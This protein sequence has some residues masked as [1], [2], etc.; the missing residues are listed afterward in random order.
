MTV[1]DRNTGIIQD[2]YIDWTGPVDI[3][4]PFII[5]DLRC[6]KPARHTRY[7]AELVNVGDSPL[8][9]LLRGNVV[10]TDVHFEQEVELSPNQTTLV[11]VDPNR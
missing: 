7:F 10:G 5:T 11:R 2:V 6:P 4:H 8:R 1:P 3:R 9:G